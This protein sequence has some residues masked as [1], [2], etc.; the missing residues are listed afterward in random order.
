MKETDNFH[1]LGTINLKDYLLVIFWAY[2]KSSL[3]PKEH[4]QNTL[5]H[6][7]ADLGM[8]RVR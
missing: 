7:L 8:E 6:K 5:S 4:N 2:L 3:I 1:L